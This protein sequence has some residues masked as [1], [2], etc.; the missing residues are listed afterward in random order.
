MSCGLRV[1]PETK[2]LIHVEQSGKGAEEAVMILPVAK[3]GT[4][5]LRQLTKPLA[6][7]VKMVAVKNQVFREYVIE[8]AQVG[9]IFRFFS[10][11]EQFT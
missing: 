1:C 9:A 2:K 8:V 4:L 5:L 7:Q 6:A 11:M 10:M 3:L